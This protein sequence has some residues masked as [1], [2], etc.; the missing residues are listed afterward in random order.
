MDR[1]SVSQEEWKEKKIILK[2]TLQNNNLQA[3]K[4]HKI[5]NIVTQLSKNYFTLL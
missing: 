5:E 4:S 2:V 3:K 1:F